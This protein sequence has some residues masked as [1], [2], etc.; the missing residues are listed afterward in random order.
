MVTFHLPCQNVSDLLPVDLP[1]SIKV[2]DPVATKDSALGVANVVELGGVHSGQDLVGKAG[3]LLSIVL[4]GRNA[5]K[6]RDVLIIPIGKPKDAVALLDEE[7]CP[8]RPRVQ[9]QGCAMNKQQGPTVKRAS[10]ERFFSSWPIYLLRF[11]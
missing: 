3:D 5:S 10:Q 1:G 11:K 9:G 6:K 2:L 7:R 4:D 8:G